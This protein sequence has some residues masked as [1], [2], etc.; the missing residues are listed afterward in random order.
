M[1]FTSSRGKA[2]SRSSERSSKS[3]RPMRNSSQANWI[4]LGSILI[5]KSKANDEEYLD[6]SE[7]LMDV[8]FNA[9]V[10]VFLPKDMDE[11]TL[12]RDD[13]LSIKFIRPRENDPDY[14]IGFLSLME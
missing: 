4:R 12:K 8:G 2:S 3:R 14:V 1:G 5:P 13:L 7:D 10:K 11:V 6:F 9:N